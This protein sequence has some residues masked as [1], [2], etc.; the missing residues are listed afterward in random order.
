M[1]MVVMVTACGGPHSKETGTD[2]DGINHTGPL[3]QDTANTPRT[4]SG[5]FGENRS[6]T[7]KRD[8]VNK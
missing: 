6:D 1:S 7:Y 4:D 8:S 3:H 5:T 2:N